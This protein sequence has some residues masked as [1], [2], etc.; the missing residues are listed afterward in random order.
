MTDDKYQQNEKK[1]LAQHYQDNKEEI[2]K[3]HKQYRQDNK[4]KIAQ[5]Q[6]IAGSKYRQKNKE[7]LAQKAKKYRDDNKESLNIKKKAKIT[8]ECGSVVRKDQIARHKRTAK[9]Q[10]YIVSII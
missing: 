3:K 2:L 6:K 5:R 10:K 8:C 7:K 9:H 4:E 1:R